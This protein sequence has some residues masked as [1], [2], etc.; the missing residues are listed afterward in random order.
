VAQSVCK[1]LT[2]VENFAFLLDSNTKCHLM[3]VVI[4]VSSGPHSKVMHWQ[5][6]NLNSYSTPKSF[7]LS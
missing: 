3:S 6:K 5:S 1:H 4:Q 2:K 7:A